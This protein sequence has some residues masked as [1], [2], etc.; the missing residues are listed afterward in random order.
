[1]SITWELSYCKKSGTWYFVSISL[2]E[3]TQPSHFPA[4]GSW[5]RP[6]VG[7]EFRI[8]HALRAIRRALCLRAGGPRGRAAQTGRVLRHWITLMKK[9]WIWAFPVLCRGLAAAAPPR[10]SHYHQSC[11]EMCRHTVFWGGKTTPLRDNTVTKQRFSLN[12]DPESFEC[13]EEPLWSA[14][15]CMHAPS[16]QMH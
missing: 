12:Y 4:Q 15:S 14:C 8:S 10:G 5:Q 13:Y 6:T 7:R 11:K 9:R 1:M 16:M 3:V 2:D